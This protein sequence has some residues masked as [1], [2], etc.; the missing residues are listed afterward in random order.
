MFSITRRPS[1]TVGALL[2]CL[3]AQ[4]VFGFSIMPEQSQKQSLSPTRLLAA[5][6]LPLDTITPPTPLEAE[7]SKVGVLLLNLGGPETGDDVE[8]E[9]WFPWLLSLV[10]ICHTRATTFFSPSAFSLR[11]L[12]QSLC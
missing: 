6:A 8:G 7:E 9:W 11:F 12:V 3:G 4:R 5:T 2:L 1:T 10:I